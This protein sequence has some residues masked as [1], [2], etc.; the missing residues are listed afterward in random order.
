MNKIPLMKHTHTPTKLRPRIKTKRMPSGAN[1]AWKLGIAGAALPALLTA[2]AQQTPAA[3]AVVAPPPKSDTLTTTVSVMAKESYDSDVFLQSQGPLANDHS[4]V[5]IVVPS[6]GLKWKP[7]KEFWLEG[8]YAPELASYSSDHSEDY[9]AH[10]AALNLGGNV[11]T[12]KWETDNS[13]NWV[14]GNSKGPTYYWAG[15]TTPGITPVPAL[16]GS[17]L[18]DRRDQAVYRD[19]FK[20]EQPIGD[21]FVRPVAT[22][23]VQDFMT[24]Q[25][26]VTHVAG[27]TSYYANYVDRNDINGGLDAGYKI[28]E[29]ADV[30]L[31]YRYGAQNQAQVVNNAANPSYSNEYQRALVGIEGAPSKWLKINAVA[32]PD[33]RT[34]TGAFIPAS[35]N[36]HKTKLYFDATASIMPSTADTI[37]LGAKRF[38]LP[39]YLG[40]SVLCD[41]IYE[42]SWRHKFTDKFSTSVGFRAEYW[43]FDAPLRKEWWYGA[44]VSAAY[45]FTAH[46]SAEASYNYDRFISG[47][48]A[49]GTANWESTRHVASL[50]VRYKF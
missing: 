28:Q 8:S 26:A 1:L 49:L 33:F 37:A 41:S 47:V 43:D 11:G 20:F 30:F 22:A 36:K 10:K 34:F 27:T 9:V 13:I 35:F 50:G 18:R 46:F 16:D 31:G 19:S 29:N 23:F 44:N 2:K 5:T 3:S 7:C 39:G 38:E 32:G 42:I 48:D 6:L 14:E 45:N 21:W 4:F 12:G 40:K 17:P 15:P 25:K 24:Q